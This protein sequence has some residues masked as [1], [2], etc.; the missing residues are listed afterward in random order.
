MASNDAMH[1]PKVQHKLEKSLMGQFPEKRY[2]EDSEEEKFE[3]P[4]GRI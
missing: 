3:E 2:D 4:S 1:F